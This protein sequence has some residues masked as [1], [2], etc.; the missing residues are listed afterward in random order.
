M[1]IF[2]DQLLQ[3]DACWANLEAKVFGGGDVLQGL[4]VIMINMGQHNAD[5]VMGFLVKEKI[6]VVTQDL[7]GSYPRKV[8]YFP[9][10][11]KVM[12][13]K[14]HNFRHSTIFIRER[15]YGLRLQKPTVAG[16]VRLFDSM[17]P[18]LESP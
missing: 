16:D 17:H 1:E 3:L 5:S 18:L 14:L 13:K 6:R 2:I 7:A 12:V 9:N 10:S 15:G 11:G 4:I 8:C